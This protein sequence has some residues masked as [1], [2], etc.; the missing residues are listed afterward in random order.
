MGAGM[1]EIV[2]PAQAVSPGEIIKMELE[3]RGWSQ[4]DL[5]EIMGRPPQAISEIIR[6]AKQITPETALELAQAFGTSAEIWM[7]LEANYRLQRARRRSGDGESDIATRSKLYGMLPIADLIRRGWLRA[8]SVANDLERDLRHLLGGDPETVIAAVS[9]RHSV[10]RGPERGAQVAWVARV[11]QLARA[12]KAPPF[13]HEALT[14]AIPTIRRLAST[15]EQVAEVPAL[16]QSLGARFI[17]VPQLPRT[18]IDGVLCDADTAPII[19]LTLRY[20]RIDSFWFTLMHELAHLVLGHHALHL[21]NLDDKAQRRDAQE[22]EANH[23]AR[24]WLIDQND[25]QAW[26]ARTRPYFSRQKIER[27]AADQQIHPGILLGQLMFDETGSY[28]HLRGLLSKVSPY[29]RD[30][31]DPAGR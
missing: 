6:G 17:I 28:K 14:R 26:V 2:H 11:R 10:A 7:N 19:G 4:R 15:L 18:Y 21:D 9:L 8:T 1:R 29:L 12:Q 27:F 24:S 20:D 25:L 13:S 23:Q 5:A 3:E 31:S 22:M 30:W 16:L